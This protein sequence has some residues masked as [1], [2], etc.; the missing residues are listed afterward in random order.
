MAENTDNNNNDVISLEG[1]DQELASPASSEKPADTASP[2]Q[3]SPEAGTVTPPPP[4]AE[5]L[6]EAAFQIIKI[7]RDRDLDQNQILDI[8]GEED[9]SFGQLVEEL[10]SHRADPVPSDYNFNGDAIGFM[11]IVG[12]L[13]RLILN[14]SGVLGRYLRRL[15][16]FLK[17]LYD[18]KKQALI[19][20]FL[21][22]KSGGYKEV[23]DKIK[24]K[25]QWGVRWAKEYLLSAWNTTRVKKIYFLLF[26]GSLYLSYFLLIKI[27]HKDKLPAFEIEGI[28]SLEQVA[29]QSFTYSETAALEQFDSPARHSDYTV[30]LGKVFANLR[31]SRQ[32]SSQPM[33]AFRFYFEASS[34]E[35]AMELVDRENEFLGQ[36][37]S[38]I[39]EMTWDELS[40]EAGKTRLKLVLRKKINEVLSRGRVKKVLIETIVL[41]N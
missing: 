2:V 26:L 4:T 22:L 9:T 1:L 37:Q 27:I 40:T 28:S 10:T 19:D 24:S 12:K 6:A 13:N 16:T 34:R 20:Y 33:G 18:Q 23:L 15:K 32:T 5:E 30:L 3:A 17:N 39:Q 25:V 31:P 8:L 35:A 21:Y 29:D 41:K 14:P 7:E 36:I 38:A 11:G